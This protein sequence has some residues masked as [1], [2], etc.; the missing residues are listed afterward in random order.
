MAHA[1]LERCVLL[2]QRAFFYLDEATHLGTNRIHQAL[3]LTTA[4][5]R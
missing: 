5:N 3:A 1:R 2:R 4:Y